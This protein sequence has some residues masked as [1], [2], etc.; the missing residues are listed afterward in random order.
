MSGIEGVGG[1]MPDRLREHSGPDVRLSQ[2]P[3]TE[4]IAD[5]GNPT[6]E[7][8]SFI[9][10]GEAGR[11][12]EILRDDRSEGQDA[13]R[14]HGEP[15]ES[16]A[17]DPMDVARLDRAAIVEAISKISSVLKEL[18]E[19][20][21]QSP[22]QSRAAE[23]IQESAKQ[24][25]PVAAE[26]LRKGAG[27]PPDLVPAALASD[28]VLRNEADS[29]RKNFGGRVW[30]KVWAE[31]KVIS[32]RLWSMIAHLVKV[33]EWTVQGQAGGGIF[34]LASASVSVTFG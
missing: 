30:D 14:E 16:G 26:M 31:V 18:G 9:A 23:R 15:G 22:D 32:V 20:L 29:A 8:M 24:L 4:V 19:A 34:G 27:Q 5:K 7:I 3:D 17:Y 2:N 1:R 13:S 21:R 33:K 28:A 25:R 6:E 10:P 11:G 12:L